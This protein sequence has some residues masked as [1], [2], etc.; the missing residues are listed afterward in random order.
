[1]K[2]KVLTPTVK[3]IKVEKGIPLPV[4]SK[5]SLLA[6]RNAMDSMEVGDSFLI[7]QN[8][9]NS[10]R[11]YFYRRA[12]KYLFKFAAKRNDDKNFRIWRIE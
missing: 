2:A 3:P 4:N 11:M 10:L 6:Y 7:S 9:I 1:M 5:G 8:Q 12:D